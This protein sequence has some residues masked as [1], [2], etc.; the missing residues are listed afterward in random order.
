MNNYVKSENEVIEDFCGFFWR[1]IK[2]FRKWF[3]CWQDLL[4]G[5]YTIEILLKRL[6]KFVVIVALKI[7][8]NYMCFEAFVKVLNA[9]VEFYGFAGMMM[10][11]YFRLMSL[12]LKE[13]FLKLI[14][15]IFLSFHVTI[16]LKTRFCNAVGVYVGMCICVCA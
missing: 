1:D 9:L 7:L 5:E 12:T 14:I 10:N 16:N 4:W 11:Q 3:C 13:I 6:I 2:G 15:W 8:I